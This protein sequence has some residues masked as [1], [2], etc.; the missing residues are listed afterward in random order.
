MFML[1]FVTAK[2]S[3]VRGGHSQNA[4]LDL[5]IASSL[6]HYFENVPILGIY[7]TQKLRI[8]WKWNLHNR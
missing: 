2:S 6:A 7:I 4:R 8:F 3:K 5:T 1:Y